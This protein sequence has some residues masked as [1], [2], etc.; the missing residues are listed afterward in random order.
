MDPIKEIENEHE[1]IE[2]GLKEIESAILEKEIN[3][4]NLIHNLRE[5][6]RIWNEHEEKEE[7]VFNFFNKKGIK[8]PIEKILFEH[9]SL[10]NNWEQIKIALN[11]GS[12]D[13]MKKSIPSIEKMTNKIREHIKKEDN[14]FYSLDDRIISKLKK[15]FRK[16][17]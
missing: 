9:R 12:D 5:L 17:Y 8:I 14:I 15:E 1:E 16:A 3:Y 7:K 13:K 10:K 6:N 11:S 4:S 2:I